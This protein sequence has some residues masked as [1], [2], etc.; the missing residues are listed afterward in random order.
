MLR[1]AVVFGMFGSLA[2]AE[3]RTCKPAGGLVVEI[4]QR[5]AKVDTSKTALYANGAWHTEVRDRGGMLARSSDGCVDADVLAG[6]LSD[7]RAAT[8][9]TTPGDACRSDSPRSTVYAWNG[10]VLYVERACGPVL[11]K[12]SRR[13]LDRITYAVHVPTLV[14]A[15]RDCTSV[16]CR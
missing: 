12:V 6:L 15:K 1:A 5:G 2:S 9:R 7:L 10:R 4:D 13:V 3:P 11:D 16:V 8:W 14:D